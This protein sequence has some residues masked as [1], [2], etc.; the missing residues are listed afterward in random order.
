MSTF[1]AGA[2]GALA[3][4]AIFAAASFLPAAAQAAIGQVDPGMAVWAGLLRQAGLR[5]SGHIAI[6]D[7]G[8]VLALPL[9]APP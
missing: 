3:S 5:P 6:D 4:A 9:D 1:R 7:G 8:P 2:I